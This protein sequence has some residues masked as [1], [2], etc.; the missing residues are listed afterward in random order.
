MSAPTRDGM[1]YKHAVCIN[2][3]L[4]R[5]GP[6]VAICGHNARGLRDRSVAAKP[7]CPDC[8][9]LVDRHREACEPCADAGWLPGEWPRPTR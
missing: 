5:P 3:A 6:R 9:D 4:L 7:E 2:Q 8:A 1:Q